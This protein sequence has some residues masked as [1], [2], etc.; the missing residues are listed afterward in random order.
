MNSRSKIYVLYTLLGRDVP[1]KANS[2]SRG[3]RD[4]SFWANW[5]DGR[6]K[7]DLATLPGFESIQSVTERALE[8]VEAIYGGSWIIQ[9]HVGEDGKYHDPCPP[10]AIGSMRTREQSRQEAEAIILAG[11]DTPGKRFLLGLCRGPMSKAVVDVAPVASSVSVEAAPVNDLPDTHAGVGVELRSCPVEAHT[12]SEV[13][14]DPPGSLD[15][16]IPF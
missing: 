10:A 4:M 5:S 12:Q 15:D 1:Y 7:G 16:D 14:Y 2:L 8:R 11:P 3:N 13:V 9:Y 6:G